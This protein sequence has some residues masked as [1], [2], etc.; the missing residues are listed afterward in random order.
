[1]P[2]RATAAPQAVPGSGQAPDGDPDRAMRQA[3]AGAAAPDAA[4][5]APFAAQPGF[6]LFPGKQPKMAPYL[7][8]VNLY[9]DQCLQSGALVSGDPISAAAQ[10][11]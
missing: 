11:V 6:A 3:D 2:P 4:D 10:A 5:Q 7:A 8:T 1:M 9:G